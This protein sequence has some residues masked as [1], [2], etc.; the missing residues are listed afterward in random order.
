MENTIVIPTKTKNNLALVILNPDI[1]SVL[2]SKNIQKRKTE[3]EVCGDGGWLLYMGGYNIAPKS[4]RAHKSYVFVKQ[5]KRRKRKG[6]WKEKET[7]A[8]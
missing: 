2:E 8:K 1:Y 5:Q 3:R 4:L 6:V 7:E